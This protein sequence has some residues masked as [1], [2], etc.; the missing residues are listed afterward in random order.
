MTGYS[1]IIN[2]SD[3]YTISTENPAAACYAVLMLGDGKYSLEG[4]VEMPMFAF[5]GNGGER[6]A[7]WWKSTF[8]DQRFDDM[9]ADHALEIA[10]NLES[11][12]IGDR[13]SYEQR[14]S[15]SCKPDVFKAQWHDLYRSS[16]NDIG[17]AAKTLAKTVRQLG[18]M[19]VANAN[20]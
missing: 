10:Q 9:L 18:V 19:E 11:V 2:P 4:D 16:V 13:E 15:T 20:N 6:A 12:V 5:G 1:E 14:L 8:P 7:E 3:H 17:K